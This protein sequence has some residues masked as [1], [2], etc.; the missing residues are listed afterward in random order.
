M[1][2][3]SEIDID[4]CNLKCGELRISMRESTQCV[5]SVESDLALT[6]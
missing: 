3:N 1:N 4:F 2:A 5:A 6:A